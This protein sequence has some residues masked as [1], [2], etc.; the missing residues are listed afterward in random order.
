MVMIVHKHIS[1]RLP[2]V[3]IPVNKEP[4]G[5]IISVN[6]ESPN[7]CIPI[8]DEPTNHVMTHYDEGV[9]IDIH[10]GIEKRSASR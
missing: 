5:A 3:I 10:D 1:K 4:S 8:N 2:D 7:V 9:N 6:K